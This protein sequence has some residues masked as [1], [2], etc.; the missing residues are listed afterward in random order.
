MLHPVIF[1]DI[2]GVLNCASLMHGYGIKIY[3][4]FSLRIRKVCDLFDA[5]IV[6]ISAWRVGEFQWEL[7]K[8]VLACSGIEYKRILDRTPRSG[9]LRGEQ[10]KTWLD[11][12]TEVEGVERPYV[13]VDDS[14][15]MLKHQRKHFVRTSWYEGLTEKKCNEMVE[16]LEDQGIP[17]RTINEGRYVL[18]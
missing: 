14:D 8:G 7:T 2:D 11:K 12:H 6:V 1:L 16:V 18:P 4:P 13:I 10:I 17:R 5:E 3:P 15:D 9:Q